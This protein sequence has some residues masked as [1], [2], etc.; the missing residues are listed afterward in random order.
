MATQHT[1]PTQ[2]YYIAILLYESA[3]PLPDYVPLYEESILL[4]I[5][6]SQEEAEDKAR[7]YAEKPNVYLNELGE[8]ITWT[9]KHVVDVN[10][11]LYAGFNDEAELYA[12]HFRNYAAYRS[13]EPRLSGEEL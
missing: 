1:R 5:A 4:L 8:T 12:R 3:A 7:R 11:I 9:L 6:T 10:P 2:T 13:F